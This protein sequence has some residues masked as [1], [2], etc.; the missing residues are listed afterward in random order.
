MHTQK[1]RAKVVGLWKLCE[2]HGGDARVSGES[3]PL[4]GA[5][6][7]AEEL[8]SLREG[9]IFHPVKRKG[10]R[11]EKAGVGIRFLVEE[12]VRSKRVSRHR[13]IFSFLP[14]RLRNV[15]RAQL[16]TFRRM[17]S[18][19]EKVLLRDEEKKFHFL[20]HALCNRAMRWR[21]VEEID[22]FAARPLFKNFRGNCERRKSK[23][24]IEME[25]HEN[26]NR[27][28]LGGSGRILRR[29]IKKIPLSL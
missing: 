1:A 19:D 11:S 13:S 27:N 5:A 16:W 29:K 3:S 4:R 26:S 9:E 15:A 21:S 2:R 20:I 25:E 14:P 23:Y 8:K 18:F 24:I 17:D 10:V 22:S 28:R 7:W 6:T 12:R